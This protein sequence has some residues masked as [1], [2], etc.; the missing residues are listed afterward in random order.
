MVGGLLFSPRSTQFLTRAGFK[1]LEWLGE[2][3]LGVL[4]TNS[5]SGPGRQ[6]GPLP[7]PLPSAGAKA[8][9][10]TSAVQIVISCC[11]TVAE[12]REAEL[13][14]NKTGRNLASLPQHTHTHTH[15]HSL[16]LSLSPH[17]PL[18]TA[19][20]SC[21]FHRVIHIPL[22]HTYTHSPSSHIFIHIPQSHTHTTHTDTHQT[23]IH[24]RSHTARCRA[25]NTASPVQ[26][27]LCV[28][29]HLPTTPSQ[30]CPAFPTSASLPRW[31]QLYWEVDGI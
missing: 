21:A 14:G 23:Y 1:E 16:S 17:L 26:P 19:T 13:G 6:E 11:R 20:Y 8:G 31:S 30:A 7:G 15:T 10:G 2:L 4:L 22:T 5:R 18:L 12:I 27:D 28:C 9:R 25:C 3:G 24:M 29:C